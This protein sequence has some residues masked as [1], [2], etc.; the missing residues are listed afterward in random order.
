MKHN[1]PDLGQ[2]IRA[3]LQGMDSSVNNEAALL[4]T[5]NAIPLDQIEVNPFQP[6]H[7]FNEVALQELANSI[8]VHG[9]V[10]PI[11]VRKIGAKKYQLIVGERRLRAAKLA[12][13]TK[14]PSFI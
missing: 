5:S 2:G 3:L 9:I 14:I 12:E 11:T 13:L 7:D 6:R 1:K 4:G 8:R 10:Q